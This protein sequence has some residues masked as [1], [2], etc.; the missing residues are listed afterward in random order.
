[1]GLDAANEL[2]IRKAL[3]TTAGAIA[4]CGYI[5]P[6]PQYFSGIE[7]YY[8]TTD[9]TKDTQIEIETQLVSALWI[10]PMLFTDDFTSGGQDSPLINLEYE[11][12]LFRQYGLM[13]ADESSTPDVF[14]AKVLYQHNQFITAWL[15][16]KESFQGNRN[17]AGL[18]PSVFV[19]AQ[20][21]SLIQIE[22]INNQA[23]CEFIPGLVGY[24]VRLRTS[25]NIKLLE[26]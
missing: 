19:T 7:D 18:D 6:A 15:A 14:D 4:A 17:I 16:L 5:K 25:V 3:A 9:G 11:F 21:T 22:D 24:A 8:A 12:Y 2:I 1:M 13:R 23:V 26:C 10:Y 20:T